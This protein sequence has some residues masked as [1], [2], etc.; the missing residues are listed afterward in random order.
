[1]KSQ[2]S[3]DNFFMKFAYQCAELSYDPHTKVGCVI[4]SGDQILSYSYNGTPRGYN[5]TCKDADGKT[6]REVVHAE[7]FA[8]GKL[9]RST[10]SADRATLYCT[11]AP[12]IECAKLI[13]ASGIRRVVYDTP[14]KDISGIKLMMNAGGVSV[15]QLNSPYKDEHSLY[16]DPE[17]LKKT[18]IP[19]EL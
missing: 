3:W 16:A 4:T 8:L 10:V 2:Q 12:C 18:G 17:W 1:M 11:L 15:F 6:K 19:D 9:A 13:I 14:Y 5:N 7:I